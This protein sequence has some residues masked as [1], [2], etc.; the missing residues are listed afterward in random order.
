MD[1]SKE[2]DD[3]YYHESD[4]CAVCQKSAQERARL[5]GDFDMLEELK[6]AMRRKP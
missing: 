5:A 3:S 4:A 6:I 1:P 2:D